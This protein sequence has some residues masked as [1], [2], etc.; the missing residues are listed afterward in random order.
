[1]PT[2]A[3]AT[4]AP[5]PGYLTVRSATETDQA[6]IIN[7]CKSSITTTYGVFMH[8]ERMRPWVDGQEVEH[9]V[10]RMWPR[11]TVAV[12][13]NTDTDEQLVGVVALDGH[14]IDLLWIQADRRGQGIGSVLMNE[15]ELMLA[16][17]HPV[18]ELEC[19]EP[20]HSSLAFYAARGYTAV[21]RYYEAASGVD[22]IVMTKQLGGV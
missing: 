9:Y 2:R 6:A 7:I 18:A 12:A 21:R 4:H 19:F 13:V 16:V 22:R 15:A 5:Y 17:D 11:M 20:N 3:V 1:M 10:A 14:V 8:A